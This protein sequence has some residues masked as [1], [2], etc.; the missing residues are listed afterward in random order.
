MSGSWP[1]VE[2]GRGL[3]HRKEFILIDDLATYKR[4]RV[5]LHAQGIVLRDQV[6]G[7]EIK[8]KRQQVCRAGNF[9]VAEIDA[10]VGGY[11]I[12]PDDLDGAI[13]SSHYFLFEVNPLELELKFLEYFIQTQA[14]FDQ[15][16]ARGTTNYAAIRP[17]NVLQYKIP[18]PGLPEQRR[19][20][21]KLATMV[22]LETLHRSV[23]RELAALRVAIF[24][25]AF[26]AAL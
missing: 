3:K 8:T 24:R 21:A 5:Q 13:V 16:T 4:C 12:V 25:R 10:K 20:V 23:T 22:E 11:G 15:V 14:F 6:P 9:L 19:T 26:N 2:L 7:S 1:L 17:N 18:L